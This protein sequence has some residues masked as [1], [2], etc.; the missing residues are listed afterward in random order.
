MV[1]VVVAPKPDQL[2]L[3][4]PDVLSVETFDGLT[5][6]FSIGKKDGDNR[7]LMVSL[8]GSAAPRERTPGKDEIPADKAKLD[9][10]FKDKRAAFDT[11]IAAERAMDKRVFLV[12]DAS[13][14]PLLQD[15]AAL[16]KKKEKPPEADKGADKK[17]PPA[18]KK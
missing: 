4:E 6:T 10:D 8:T 11:R 2:G 1:D 12:T 15:R 14:Q 16:L 3:T 7:A 17:K 5:Y 9:Q 18:K 13:V